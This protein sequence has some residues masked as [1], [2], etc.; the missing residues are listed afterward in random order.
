VQFSGGL[1]SDMRWQALAWATGKL[2]KHL[3]QRMAQIHQ[4]TQLTL[5]GVKIG[6]EK[7]AARW[8]RESPVLE[9]YRLRVPNWPSLS[10][11]VP[12]NKTLLPG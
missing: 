6:S 12:T 7:E 2:T 10:K 11:F 3:P 1:T 4:Q 5:Y 8:P 9:K